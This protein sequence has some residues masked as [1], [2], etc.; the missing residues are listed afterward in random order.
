LARNRA[1][2]SDL[3]R[4]EASD[5]TASRRRPCTRQPSNGLGQARPRDRLEQIVD[6]LQLE[7]IDRVLVEGG[8]ED[9][10]GAQRGE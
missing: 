5:D 1:G 6:R 8:A 3:V 2:Y 4:P 9:Q 10:L 7:G